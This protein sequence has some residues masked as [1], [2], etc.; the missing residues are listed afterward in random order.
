MERLL[1]WV[2]RDA[3]GHVRK[4]LSHVRGV[5]CG[6]EEGAEGWARG[7]DGEGGVSDRGL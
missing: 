6:V 1:G 3:G 4:E 2:K 7:T 5:G